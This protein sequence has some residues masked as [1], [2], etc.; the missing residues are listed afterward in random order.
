MEK[1]QSS[2][3]RSGEI[4]M[5]LSQATDLAIG[6]PVE[7]ALKSCILAT[8]MG[9]LLALSDEK[10]G[11]IFYQSL[12]RYIGCNAE[13]HAMAALFDD[14]IEF[15]RGFALIDPGRASEMA[16][17]VFTFLRR[18]NSNAGML[19]MVAG[20]ARGLISSKSASAEILS[21]HCEVAERLARRLG[22]SE[23]VQ[24]N[25]GQLYE[26]WDGRGMPNG[27]KGEAVSQ[28]V[29]IVS[30][31][32]D[33]IVL[34]AAF[35]AE[36]ACAK[37]ISRSGTVYEPGL[38]EKFSENA[39][40]LADGLDGVTWEQVLALEPEPHILL[41]EAQF[42]AACLAAAD[43]IDLKT[44]WSIGHS[45]AVAALAGEAA[46]RFGLTQA[47]A[48]DIFRAGLLHDIGQAAV[49]A[50][51]L[52]KPG[53]F[54]DGDWEQMRLHPYYGGRVLARPAALARLGEIVAQ[55]HERGDGSG[56]HRGARGPALSAQ[57]K[58]LAAA[59]AY[60]NKIE[61][62]PHRAALTRDAAASALKR[63]AREGRLDSEAVAAVLA[64]AGHTVTLRKD[65]LAGLTQRELDVLRA[66]AKG[67]SMKECARAMGISPKTVDNHTQS[68]YS[69]IGVKTRGGATLFAIEHGL[70]QSE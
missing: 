24:R 66:I 7:F 4:I 70:Y 65:S 55:H 30:F 22:L 37:L 25:L 31:A 33:A 42:D 63:E 8:R 16:G 40:T 34:E 48:S 67:Q 11:E 53:T 38:A 52:M 45:R 61:P 39:V 3:V 12:L 21:G 32:Q 56:Y 2:G 6:Q 57:G 41:S 20:M 19:E 68:V 47:D 10:L 51:I 15:R 36:A 13:T 23:A 9:R 49:P 44:P 46:R 60:Q 35:G 18:A 26:R 5:A 29:R 14:E 58:I 64:A 50:R 27:L 28:A 43:F 17:L 54:N 69:K 1:V 59:E 62:R